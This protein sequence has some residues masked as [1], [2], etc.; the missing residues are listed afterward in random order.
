MK[1]KKV[2]SILL[3]TVLCISFLV[4]CGENQEA[5]K[6]ADGYMA[7]MNDFRTN[8]SRS[9]EPLDYKFAEEKKV[10]DL[11]Y[12]TYSIPEPDNLS[13]PT[14]TKVSFIFN[15]KTNEF[16]AMKT[17]NGHG[18]RGGEVI[19]LPLT[20]A[21]IDDIF[22]FDLEQKKLF[23]SKYLHANPPQIGDYK[24]LH[25]GG[26]PNYKYIVYQKDYPNPQDL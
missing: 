7:A 16:V 4:G 17:V 5:R 3:A 13:G 15:N 1:W 26:A 19:G 8:E 22:H 10:D 14:E 20:A 21:V 12:V 11:Y 24:I 9:K 23:S 6:I 2:I 25:G 18:T